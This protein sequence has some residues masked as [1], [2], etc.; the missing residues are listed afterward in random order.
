[1]HAEKDIYQLIVFKGE[2]E[3]EVPNFAL[4][5]IIV[6]KFIVSLLQFFFD[7]LW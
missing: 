7:F 2:S 6:V 3:Q 1:M 5:Y 4:C